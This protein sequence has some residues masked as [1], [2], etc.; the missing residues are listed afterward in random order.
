[1]KLKT[2]LFLLV[3]VFLQFLI[4][5][6]V[7]KRKPDQ[8]VVVP[9]VKTA[10]DDSKPGY[11]DYDKLIVKLKEW[12]EQS[13][14][15]TELLVYGKST[16]GNDLYC[17]RI[18]NEKILGDRPKILIT[19]CIHGNE[20]WSTATMMWYVGDLL[21]NYN[22]N[23]EIKKLLDSREIY[24][25]PVVS[26]DS[27]PHSRHVDGVDPNR[28]FYD[29]SDRKSVKPIAALQDFFLKIKPKAVLSGH[30]WGRVY[31]IPYGD[32]MENCP[33]HEE[34]VRLVGKMAELSGYRYMRA[35]DMYKGSG[36]LN[37]PP[38]RTYG[39]DVEGYNVM[40]PIYGTEMDWYYKNDAFAVVMEFGTHQRKPS[41]EEIQFEF[42]KTYEAF[43]YF[44]TEAPVVDLSMH[45][46]R[47]LLKEEVEV[48][49]DFRDE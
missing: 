14:D 7:F 24:F 46:D 15:L 20:P 38:I 22:D 6:F 1:M 44:L 17:L 13:Q 25:I 10:I 36:K 41:M 11:L 32:R 39:K 12:N 33:D 2:F 23:V 40:I 30:T 47:A 35:C 21:K 48:S 29:T 4:L 49:Q 3:C 43:V 9:E 8:P 5:G 31:L 45:I 27:Y 16:K 18:S 42:E 28:N 26:P 19:A 34:F 37:N